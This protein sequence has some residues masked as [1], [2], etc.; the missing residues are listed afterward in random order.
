[1]LQREKDAKVYQ[2]GLSDNACRDLKSWAKPQDL[3]LCEVILEAIRKD[4]EN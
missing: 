2:E 4:Q 1:M 3:S